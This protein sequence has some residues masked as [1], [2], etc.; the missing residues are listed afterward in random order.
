MPNQSKKLQM[1]KTLHVSVIIPTYGRPERLP[2]LL[3]QLLAQE[4]D[5]YNYEIIVVDDGSKEPV[6]LIVDTVSRQAKVPIKCLRKENGGPASARNLG[7]QAAQGEYLLFVDD[8]SS[9]R[10]DFLRGHIETQLQFGPAVI[11]CEAERQIDLEPEPFR[12][13]YQSQVARWNELRW[14]GLVPI[15][16]DVFETPHPEVTSAN[17]SVQRAEF[18]RAGGF[19]VNYPFGCEDQDFGARLGRS[20]VRTLL[21]RKTVA[22]HAETHTTLKLLCRRQRIG[23]RDTV[24]FIQ[25]FAVEHHCGEPLIAAVNGPI[26]LGAESWALSAKKVLRQ[27]LVA[28]FLS[29]GVFAG[30]HVLE[31]LIPKSGLLQKMYDLVVGAYIQKGW[32][33]G[34]RMYQTELPLKEWAPASIK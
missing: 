11:N 15:A 30:I 7:A 20:G 31:Y 32:R 10:P 17:M 6:S 25:R 19:D 1:Q 9:V 8:D 21:T 5:S 29:G 14:A 34:L 12:R 24:R 3:E 16:E 13:W 27:F 28:R 26:R 23:A 4:A 33:E 2:K 22:I 18:E